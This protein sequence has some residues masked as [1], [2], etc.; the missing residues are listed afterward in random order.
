MLLK[1]DSIKTTPV[2]VLCNPSTRRVELFSR[3]LFD[4][5]LPPPRLIPYIDILD[6]R[7]DLAKE[8]SAGS[9]VRLES[10]G[11]DF[12]VERRLLE[13]GET[14]AEE[15]GCAL[16]PGL[17]L[18]SREFE[19]GRILAPRQWYHGWC[20][21]LQAIAR[22]LQQAPEH[23]LMNKVDDIRL[24]YDKPLCH[25]ALRAS[26]IPV[27]K[28]FGTVHSFAELQH[29]I[30]ERQCRRLFL[31]VANGSSASGVVAYETN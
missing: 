20:E 13:W 29:L 22:Q 30:M 7:V 8:I 9:I 11:K 28:G 1:L 26:S 5:G 15:Q 25:A 24:M 16:V 21:L 14:K 3:S 31:K 18:R 10:P 2:V 17:Q 4:L 23:R 12:Q 27:P 6:N 19:R